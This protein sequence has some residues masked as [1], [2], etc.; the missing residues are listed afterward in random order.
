MR[1]LT[2]CLLLAVVSLQVQSRPV[3]H[4]ED[5]LRKEAVAL[6]SEYDLPGMTVAFVLAD[7]SLS[8]IAV[9]MA[10][11]ETGAAM[12]PGSRMLAASIGKTFVGATAVCLAEEGR[13]DLDAPISDYLEKREWFSRLP[14]GS[15]ITLRHL[16]T[17]RSG[18]ADHVKLASFFQGLRERWPMEGPAFTGEELVG[19]VLD[20]RPLFAPGKDWS[21]S[22]TGFVLAG[23]I[24]EE[25]C[26][27][28]LYEEVAERFLE[29]LQ[30][31]HT[32]PSN[33][34]RLP[35]LV[36]GYT[37]RDNPFGF[38]R[39][40]VAC[41]GHLHWHPGVEDFGG[42][43][44]SSAGDLARW[45]HH[46]YHGNILPEAAQ[47]EMLKTY[48]IPASGGTAGYGIAVSY[49]RTDG[50]GPTCGHGGWIPGYVSSLRYY[51]E[52]GLTVAFQV[53]SDAVEA[54]GWMQALERRLTLSILSSDHQAGKTDD[55]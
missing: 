9:G 11:C 25:V 44:V 17:H 8:E 34:R 23:M 7:G 47:A 32:S 3:G 52:H 42:G 6:V 12:V 43:W 19:F 16:L 5:S 2:L 31:A 46:L 26:D 29:P 1:S 30:L 38:P 40:S 10:D 18:L 13:V 4:L 14:S 53:N 37:L 24:L 36:P 35:G 27:R 50:L 22:D 33:S 21:Y 55:E 15:Q 48:P 51:S 49:R 45:G 39:K 54:A 20:T 41:N 28:T